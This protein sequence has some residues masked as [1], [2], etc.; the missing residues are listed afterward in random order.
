MSTV[1]RRSIA[2]RHGYALRSSI[3]GLAELSSGN[4]SPTVQAAA[5]NDGDNPPPQ[6]D[7]Y[8]ELQEL[9]E[10]DG[11][12]RNTELIFCLMCDTFVDVFDGIIIRDCLHHV[13][14]NCIRESIFL[15]CSI[16]VKCPTADCESSLQ[17][18]E[19]RSLLTQ[20]EYGRHMQ[21]VDNNE[22]LYKELLDFE[23]N[24]L[25]R[26]CD[27]FECEICY[28]NIE[29]FDGALLR[30]CL[31]QFCIDCIRS[32]INHSEEAEIKCPADGC[33]C[34]IHDREI[35]SL[36]TQTE[37]DKYTAKILRIAESK[38]TNSYHCK[39]ANCEGWCIVEDA[40]NTFICPRGNSQNCLTCK[41]QFPAGS[42]FQ[43][44]QF[45]LFT[46]F[47]RQFIRVKIANNIK[48]SSVTRE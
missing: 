30:E 42:S 16:N 34:F 48:K 44:N 43:S 37:F 45:S 8:K 6:N 26:N 24:N 35:R 47:Y 39:L 29:K 23:D 27:P 20:S 14:I 12:I 10:Q 25:I 46:H 13:C 7:L 22:Q 15:C 32:T 21:K 31:H 36:L 17:D 38:A 19:I 40:V 11:V 3:G 18:R 1:A 5:P 9:E 33:E 2:H 41:V 4:A 28:T